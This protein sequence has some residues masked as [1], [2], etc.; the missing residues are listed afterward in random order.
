MHLE[1]VKNL[2]RDDLSIA[3]LAQVRGMEEY[4]SKSNRLTSRHAL[5]RR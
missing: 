1:A 4:I 5:G 2:Y 3:K